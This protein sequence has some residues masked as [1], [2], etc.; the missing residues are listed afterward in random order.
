MVAACSGTQVGATPSPTTS[1]TGSQIPS[2]TPS[3]APA[4]T[5]PSAAIVAHAERAA[6][7]LRAR[8]GF[9]SAPLG[10]GT[11]LAVG[12]DFACHPGPA[13]PG[14]E[15]AERYDPVTDTWTA[16]QSLNKPRKS[17]AMVALNDGGA[18]VVGG[19]NADEAAFSSTKLFDPKSATWSD[20]PLLG[21]AVGEPLAATL[22]DGRV[23]TFRPYAF[24]ETGYATAV[25]LY[26]PAAGRWDPAAE[27][28]MYVHGVLALTDGGLLARGSA[29]ESPELLYRY[30]P[31]VDRWTILA[32]PIE[33]IS[34]FDFGRFGPLS[35]ARSSSDPFP[36]TRVERFAD[37]TERWSEAASM[38]APREAAMVTRLADGRVLVAGG[39]TSFETDSTGR[40]LATTEIYD[41]VAD[42]WTAG[43]D[44]LEPRKA[45]HARQLPD[46]SVLLFGGDD[47][48]NTQGDVPWCPSPKTSTERV[49]LGS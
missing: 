36:S 10:D 19:I 14:S 11:I 8:T 7:M 12:D 48:F 32:A 23:M 46:G 41:P 28:G 33:I 24:G 40:T 18:M 37:A 26:D 9:D 13:T 20:G 35:V 21:R 1:P 25:E 2:S 34:T 38:S 3:S 47:D 22:A 31:A 4:T 42:R 6:P 39:G 17:F 27:V 30:D 5:T 45:G 15:T 49:Y 43:P 44:L 16:T 29:F